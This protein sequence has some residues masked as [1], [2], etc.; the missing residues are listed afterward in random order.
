MGGLY[1]YIFAGSPIYQY[2]VFVAGIRIYFGETANETA[3]SAVL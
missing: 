1:V 3:R 2:P